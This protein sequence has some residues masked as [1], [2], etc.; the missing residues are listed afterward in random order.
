M[1]Q[2]QDGRAIIPIFHANQDPLCIQPE[3]FSTNKDFLV[4]NY[5]V[6]LSSKPRTLSSP[7]IG[8]PVSMVLTGYSCLFIQLMLQWYLWYALLSFSVSQRWLCLLLQPSFTLSWETQQINVKQNSYS[9]FW[10]LSIKPWIDTLIS[11]QSLLFLYIILAPATLAH[12]PF[13]FLLLR[14]GKC[15]LLC[16][17][18]P[19]LFLCEVVLCQSFLRCLPISFPLGKRGMRECKPLLSPQYSFYLLYTSHLDVWRP[20]KKRPQVVDMQKS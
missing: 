20:R 5:L 17:C 3:S 10:Y 8:L 18:I 7:R 9:E 13:P 14:E 19:P 4:G 15:L 2:K 16:Y 1:K 6:P 11:Q 12:I